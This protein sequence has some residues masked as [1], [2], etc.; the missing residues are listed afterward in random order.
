[1]CGQIRSTKIDA[2]ILRD[3]FSKHFPSP[4]A[5]AT[6]PQVFRRSTSQVPPHVL[7]Y[8]LNTQVE[9][10]HIKHKTKSS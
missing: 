6:V 10:E 3:I 2:T 5:A 7:K 4:S 1:M 9:I 8:L